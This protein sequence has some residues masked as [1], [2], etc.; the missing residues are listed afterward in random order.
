MVKKSMYWKN[1]WKSIGKTKVRF[2]SI[3]AIVFLGAMVF[4]GL[5]NTPGAMGSPQRYFTKLYQ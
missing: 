2:I 1:L 5:R 3:F 4:A